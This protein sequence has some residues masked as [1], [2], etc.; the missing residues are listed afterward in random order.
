MSIS[1]I[2]RKLKADYLQVKKVRGEENLYR[3]Y[4]FDLNVYCGGYDCCYTLE[5]LEELV[6]DEN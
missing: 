5:E 2:Q 4:N 6:S 3:L 1:T